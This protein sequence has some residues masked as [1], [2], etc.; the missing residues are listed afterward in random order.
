MA[1]S[2]SHAILEWARSKPAGERYDYCSNGNCAIAQFLR[3]TGRA[4][5]PMVGFNDWCEGLWGV[6][7]FFDRRIAEAA[8]RRP[9]TFGAFAA[10]L[11]SALA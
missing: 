4:K 5:Q 9:E 7:H 8:E 3:E 10:R 6:E 11:E 1:L 2:F